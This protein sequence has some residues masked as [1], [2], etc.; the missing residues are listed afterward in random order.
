MRKSKFS[1]IFLIMLLSV[2]IFLS[3]C[4]N[5]SVKEEGQNAGVE[6]SDGK[7][8]VLAS[9][10]SNRYFAAN[11]FT[12]ENGA[13]GDGI[14]DDTAAIQATLNKASENGGG[15]VYIKLGTYK[16]S[17]P[18]TIPENVT[19][20]GDFDSPSKKNYTNGGTLLLV[21]EN[22]S[23][24]NNPL[25]ILNNN[26]IIR[27][28]SIEYKGQ[29]YNNIKEYP[30]TIV[31]NEGTNVKIANVTLLNSY[32][33]ISLSSPDT[34]YVSLE[35]IFITAFDYGIQINNCSQKL[36][37][38][39]IKFSP[40]YWVNSSSSNFSMNDIAEDM[41]ENLTAFTLSQVSDFSLYNIDIDTALN[42]IVVSVP[43]STDGFAFASGIEVRNTYHPIFLE[44]AGKNGIA[45]AQCSLRTTDLLDTQTIKTGEGFVTAAVFNGC[46]FLGQ[47][48]DTVLA[49]GTGK[50]SFMNCEFVSWRNSALSL[51]NGIIT[52]INNKFS[53]SR[54]LGYL[55]EAATALLY[56]NQ[57]A[58]EEGINSIYFY[59]GKSENE[60]KIS[61]AASNTYNF[62]DTA[63]AINKHVVN[64]ETFGLSEESEDNTSAIQ[65]A[66]N[67]AYSQGG[68]IVFIPEGNYKVN[69]TITVRDN[70]RLMGVS[71]NY[72]QKWSTTLTKPQDM[73]MNTHFIVLENGSSVTDLSLEYSGTPLFTTVNDQGEEITLKCDKSFAMQANAKAES[74]FIENVNFVNTHSGINLNGNEKAILKNITGT[75]FRY[76]IRISNTNNILV[77]NTDFNTNYA[78]EE[79]KIYQ[80]N[81]LTAI[82]SWNNN[83]KMLNNSV[84]NAQY[85]VYLTGDVNESSDSPVFVSESLFAR[86]I[87]IGA[88]I[89][90]CPYSVFI[91]TGMQTKLF[92]S[93]AHHVST[94]AE[95]SG[96]CE[97]YNLLGSGDTT[98]S[99]NNRS[100]SM[101][102][103][104]SF[105]NSSATST[106]RTSSG[107]FNSF[108]NIIESLPSEYHFTAEG[109]TSFLF[110]NIVS[111]SKEFIGLETT[112]LN[113]NISA[114]ATATE[115][116]NIKQPE[117]V[118]QDSDNTELP[119]GE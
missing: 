107:T 30:F 84:T 110:G 62:N 58:L 10:Q 93:T 29:T 14:T 38:E 18:I 104:T 88:Y 79:T 78:T 74:I 50:L 60:I 15:T 2:S 53:A 69:G 11:F 80:Q 25:I 7:A 49:E 28:I 22:E 95:Y 17:A 42:G 52:G 101:T 19:L 92:S 40:V 83:I 24:L 106:L 66:I 102:V 59:S 82:Y 71:S 89:K 41:N 119:S 36:Y 94:D 117:N 77:K 33:G 81:N 112:Y 34:E 56:N 100:G 115:T 85:G 3:S 109:G 12:S 72:G 105:I 76:G 108:A 96:N 13:I 103:Q 113:K 68:G 27:D 54:P 97:I 86:D 44:S 98:N 61:T 39:N 26:S 91:N 73:E 87:N 57:F 1:F 116:Y 48:Y 118:V 31:Q 8:S 32:R 99:I 46:S 20:H 5:E 23:T 45:F 35:N 6:I 9:Y 114:E 21:E 65:Q 75:V 63:Y 64:A 111:S 37:A 4:G 55:S 47:P 51:S 43:S 70:I 67:E 16:I 90:N